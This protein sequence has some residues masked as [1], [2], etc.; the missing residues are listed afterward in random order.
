LSAYMPL[1][2]AEQIGALGFIPLVATGRLIGKFMVYYE[3]GHDFGKDEIE[4]ATAIANHFAAAVARF[5]MIAALQNSVRFNEMF[6]GMLGH[7]LRNPLGAIVTAAQVAMERQSDPRIAKPLTRILSSGDRMAR[8]IDHLL[9]FTRVRVGKGIPLD[10]QTFDIAAGLRQVLEEFE[11]AWPGWSLRMTV[12]GDLNGRWDGDRLLQV[13]SNLIANAIQHG[14]MAHGVDINADGTA[15]DAVCIEI[16]NMGTIPESLLPSVFEPMTGGERR[17]N[18][19]HSLGLGLFIT[20]E[21]VR[22]H[23][24]HIDVCSSDAEGTI[25]RMRLPRDSNQELA[26]R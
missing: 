4:L 16:R 7:D 24:G 19:S 22:A 9:D 18:N 13:F 14:V 23:H 17:Q 8:M 10:F 5:Q 3:G 15:P 2:A 6:T 21:I 12:R 20:R 25:F 11:D 1:F 26:G